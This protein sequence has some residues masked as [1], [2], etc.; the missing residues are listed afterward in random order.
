MPPIFLQRAQSFPVEALSEGMIHVLGHLLEELGK[1]VLAVSAIYVLNTI[2]G[3]AMEVFM[4]IGH[5]TLLRDLG[6][7]HKG[8]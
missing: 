1:D 7:L 8:L 5:K 2:A 6:Y 3:G 4:N